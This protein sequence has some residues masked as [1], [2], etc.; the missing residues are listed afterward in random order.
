MSAS[1]R[2]ATTNP[3]TSCPGASYDSDG[4]LIV[5]GNIIVAGDIGVVGE[6]A[7]VDA[8]DYEALEDV[9]VPDLNNG[10]SA[11]EEDSDEKS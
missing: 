11:P 7:D 1:P 2:P 5:P 8:G 9:D 3:V 6:V 10:S 4:N